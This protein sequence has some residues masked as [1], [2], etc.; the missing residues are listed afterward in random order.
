MYMNYKDE[1]LSR[2]IVSLSVYIISN[3]TLTDVGIRHVSEA[4]LRSVCIGQHD[5]IADKTKT[6]TYIS[7][8]FMQWESYEAEDNQKQDLCFH[9]TPMIYHRYMCR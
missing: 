3:Q 9:L 2:G 7:V 5:A 8:E 6:G 1:I 4:S